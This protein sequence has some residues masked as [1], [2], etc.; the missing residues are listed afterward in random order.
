MAARSNK[1]ALESPERMDVKVGEPNV[2]YVAPPASPVNI[3]AGYIA[4]Y[5][6]QRTEY[7]KQVFK[8]RLDLMKPEDHSAALNNI[9]TQQRALLNEAQRRQEKSVEYLTT[10]VD[11]DLKIHE[12]DVM[13]WGKKTEVSMNDSRNAQSA[14]NKSAELKSA[15]LRLEAQLESQKYTAELGL[16][17]DQLKAGGKGPGW[18]KESLRAELSK[19]RDHIVL[20]SQESPKAVRE[21]LNGW[22]KTLSEMP[23]NSDEKKEVVQQLWEAAESVT[24]S[25]LESDKNLVP[26]WDHLRDLPGDR[27]GDPQTDPAGGGGGATASGLTRPTVGKLSSGVGTAKTKT[28]PAPSWGG[29]TGATFGTAVE[30]ITKDPIYDL[31]S[32]QEKTLYESLEAQKKKLTPRHGEIFQPPPA[33]AFY[34]SGGKGGKSDGEVILEALLGTKGK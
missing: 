16:Q 14:M 18:L 2:Y 29:A 15:A 20:A 19:A 33:S 12:Q 28:T 8:H 3:F 9:A 7:A 10:G 30:D 13:V 21:Q 6:K 34:G 11:L 23:M 26:I 25:P 31:L 5:L 24:I 32:P 22:A 1:M 27:P 4:S 17:G